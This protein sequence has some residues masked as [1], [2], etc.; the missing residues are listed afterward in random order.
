MAIK[1]KFQIIG[2]N[3]VILG[4]YNELTFNTKFI[5]MVKLERLLITKE[6]KDH[7]GKKPKL[8]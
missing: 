2:L 5:S 1:F 4:K 3:M 7:I 6:I 8:F